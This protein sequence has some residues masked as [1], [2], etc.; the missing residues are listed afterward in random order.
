MKFVSKTSSFEIVDD[1]VIFGEGVYSMKKTGNR[2][3][4]SHYI[5]KITGNIG[6][7]VDNKTGDIQTFFSE[8]EIESHPEIF[9]IKK[10]TYVSINGNDISF[11]GEIYPVTNKKT[12]G[13][14]D[15]YICSAGELYIPR[16]N[17]RIAKWNGVSISKLKK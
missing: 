8:E 11:D 15:V 4:F 10:N 6:T 3:N 5:L 9:I 14:V 1:K 17:N 7:L 2:I 13:S 16:S 12:V